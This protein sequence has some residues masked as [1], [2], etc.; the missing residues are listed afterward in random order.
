LADKKAVCCQCG[1]FKKDP[2]E[3]CGQCGHEPKEDRDLACHLFLS[4]YCNKAAHLQQCSEYIRSGKQVEFQP[5][6]LEA[7]TKVIH[8]RQEQRRANR[9]YVAKLWGTFVLMLAISA[10]VIWLRSKA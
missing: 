10:L 4:T 5:Q 3:K 6:Q 9:L 7:A 8:R 1:S 2:F